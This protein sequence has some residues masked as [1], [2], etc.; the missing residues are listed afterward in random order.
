MVL[1]LVMRIGEL[2]RLAGVSPRTVRHYHQVGVLPEP[3]RAANGYREYGLGDAVLL[4]RARRLVDVGLALEEVAE[5]LRDDRGRDLDE[6]LAEVA[7]DLADRERALQDQRRRIVELRSRLHTGRTDIADALDEEGLVEFFDAIRDA[8][9]RGAA[10]ERDRHLLSLLEGENATQVAAALAEVGAD[11][12]A[13]ARLA[14]LYERFDALAHEPRPEA[15]V[16]NELAAGILAELPL[17]M[18]AQAREQLHAGS[19]VDLALVTHDLSAGQQ[20]V[21]DALVTSL[22]VTPDP[23]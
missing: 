17:S 5:V 3:A 12:Q 22:A 14:V 9:G 4:A 21:V 20:L 18:V 23:A 1:D 2:A 6:L 15:D 7:A 10:V 19:A 8:G 13:A 11:K 16:V